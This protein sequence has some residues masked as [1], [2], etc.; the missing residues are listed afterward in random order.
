MSIALVNDTEENQST[1][2]KVCPGTT[3]STTEWTGTVL[4]TGLQGN[5]PATNHLSHDMAKVAQHDHMV[6]LEE[7]LCM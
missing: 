1:Y 4:N 2:R 6:S 7:I 3:L 5:R